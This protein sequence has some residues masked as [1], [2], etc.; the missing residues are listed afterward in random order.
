MTDLKGLDL[1]KAY[2]NHPE[3]FLPMQDH[4]E[5]VP[6]KYEYE[7]FT[8]HNIGWYAGLLEENRPFFAECWAS[9]G[10]TMLTIFVSTIGI[11]DKSA[12]ELADWFQSI[13]YYKAMDASRL[14]RTLKYKDKSGNE[15]FSIN[16]LVGVNEE[17]AVIEGGTILPWRILNEYN[18]VC[19]SKQTD[20]SGQNP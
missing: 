11:E 2:R 16:I 13:G 8:D 14:P 4:P 1:V 20:E 17:P 19:L 12:A 5:Q 9:E 6:A 7:Y 15:F 3:R 18:S 10:I